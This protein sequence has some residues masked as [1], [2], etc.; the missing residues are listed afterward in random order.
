MIRINLLPVRELEAQ[1]ARRR[2]LMTGG[3]FLGVTFLGILVVFG[4]QYLSLSRLQTEMDDLEREIA[5]LTLEAKGVAI[6]QKK[7]ADFKSKVKV[8][9]EL[10]AKKTGPVKVLESLSAATPARLWLTEFKETE[11][12]VSINGL[13][14][15]N[16]A[17]AEFLK[18]LT[19]TGFFQN[20]ELIESLQVD[21]NGTALKRFSLRSTLLY[22]IPAKT[23]RTG[24]SIEEKAGTKP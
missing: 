15:D 18:A 3:L 16:Q 17:V 1:I 20:V 19:A 8:I 21:Q 24:N 12:S 11:G 22:Q 9:E 6:L 5:A 14:V 4:Y 2:E 7:V 23:E 10:E 13:A